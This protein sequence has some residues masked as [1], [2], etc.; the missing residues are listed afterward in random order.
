VH[1][2]A[3][4]GAAHLVKQFDTQRLQCAARFDA[5]LVA[6]IAADDLPVLS[7]ADLYFYP[8]PPLTQV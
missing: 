7:A 6:M 4:C 1:G 8:V 3:T 2:T 5:S